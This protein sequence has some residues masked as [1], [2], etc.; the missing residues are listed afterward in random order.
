MKIFQ[1]WY[2]CVS[3]FI[4]NPSSICRQTIFIMHGILRIPCIIRIWISFERFPFRIKISK[5]KMGLKRKMIHTNI[6]FERFSY[7]RKER[8]VNH[9]MYKKN[10]IYHKIYVYNL[11][12]HIR[13]PLIH[14]LI[15]LL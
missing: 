4:S 6:K 8:V 3:L 9:T 13:I 5:W 2:W 7:I 15:Y 12:Y 10:F 14:I 11:K 1:I